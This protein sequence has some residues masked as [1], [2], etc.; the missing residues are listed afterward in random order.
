MG[1]TSKIDLNNLMQVNYIL[2]ENPLGM[3]YMV[4]F[5]KKYPGRIHHRGSSLPSIDAHSDHIECQGGNFYFETQGPN[6]N[7][8]TGAIVGG[9]ASDD[10][11]QDSREDV[12]ESEPMTY[13]NAPLVGLLAYFHADSSHWSNIYQ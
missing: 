2:G 9:P 12:T 13:V 3:S 1:S 7:L 11:F 6:P 10:S 4:G 8:L 5:G